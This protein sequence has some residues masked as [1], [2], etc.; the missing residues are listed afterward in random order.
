MLSLEKLVSNFF[1]TVKIILL[2]GIEQ[3]MPTLQHLNNVFMTFISSEGNITFN[4]ITLW[5]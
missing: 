3:N 4:I 2:T 5:G 1:I